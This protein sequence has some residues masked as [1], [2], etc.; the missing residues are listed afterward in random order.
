ME[1]LGRSFFLLTPASLYNTSS[2]VSPSTASAIVIGSTLSLAALSYSI[3]SAVINIGSS[4]NIYD[5]SDF[6]R[7]D[8]EDYTRYDDEDYTRYDDQDL[9]YAYRGFK[10]R[11]IRQDDHLHQVEN[12]FDKLVEAKKHDR[13]VI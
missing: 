13:K 5:D 3:Y 2:T 9:G 1:W 7:Y 4:Y 11:S 8:D 12:V 10:K 6:T